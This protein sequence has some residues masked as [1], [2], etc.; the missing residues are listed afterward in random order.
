MALPAD[1]LMGNKLAGAPPLSQADQSKRYG[2]VWYVKET[3]LWYSPSHLAD[4]KTQRARVLRFKRE[5]EQDKKKNLK[6][7]DQTFGLED[8]DGTVYAL[9]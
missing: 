7:L 2:V 4:F 6:L 5:N 9:D 1:H 3:G 8:E